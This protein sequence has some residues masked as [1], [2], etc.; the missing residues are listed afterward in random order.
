MKIK[1]LS[2]NLL[3]SIAP[4]PARL[5]AGDGWSKYEKPDVVKDMGSGYK[6]KSEDWLLDKLNGDKVVLGAFELVD[7]NAE[8]VKAFMDV[9][10]KNGQPF[11]IET[12][13]E[14]EVFLKKLGEKLVE[15]TMSKSTLVNHMIKS[16][17]EGLFAYIANEALN[18][19]TSEPYFIMSEILTNPRLIEVR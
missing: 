6:N 2:E 1:Y 3:E 10:E 14:H 8:D 4:F 15:A 17:D 7:C 19:I 16:E 13:Y 18:I 12:A 11:M 9:L 5:V